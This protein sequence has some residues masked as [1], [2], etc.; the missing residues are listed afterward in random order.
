MRSLLVLASVFPPEPNPLLATPR[1]VTETAP[2]FAKLT[3][4]TFDNLTESKDNAPDK[5]LS[6]I[7]LLEV[8]TTRAKREEVEAILPAKETDLQTALVADLQTVASELE[9]DAKRIA[10]ENV[11]RG[12]PSPCENSD[13]VSTRSWPIETSRTAQTSRVECHGEGERSQ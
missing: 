7:L 2:V 13:T 3:W 4:T 9:A 5:V 10:G 8:M 12:D 11:D 6:A 1:T